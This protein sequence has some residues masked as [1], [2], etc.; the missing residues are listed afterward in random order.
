[1]PRAVIYLRVSTDEQSASGLGLEAQLS[2]CKAAASRLGLP[3]AS[4]HQ[5]DVSGGLPLEKRPGLLEAIV[6]L[7]PGDSLLV[8]KL[9]RLSR[10]D[11]I[12]SGMIEAAVLRWKARIVSAAG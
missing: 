1:M 12:T 11:P 10:G 8:A 3:V 4:V 9:D 2:A 6:A 5:D 7:G